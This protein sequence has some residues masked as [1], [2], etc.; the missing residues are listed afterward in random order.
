MKRL[1]FN[2]IRTAYLDFFESKGH[3]RLKSYS[4]VPQDDPSLLLINAGMAP[5]KKY[6]LGEKK[7]AKNR[8]TSSQRCVR[9]ADIENVGK[10][11]RHATYFEML[12]N[13]SFGDY[14]KNEAIHWAWE[15]LTRVIEL[16]PKRLWITVYKE[17]REAYR[18]WHEGIGVPEDRLLRLGKEDNF[19]ELDQGPCGP[20]SEIHYDRGPAFGPGTNPTDNSDR[21]MELWNLVFTQFNKQP[22]GSYLPI[23]HPNIDTGMGLERLALVLEDK[24]NIFEVEEFLPMREE[25]EKLS[26]KKYGEDPKIDESFRVIIDH[27][28]AVTFLAMDGVV[29]SNAGRG[30]ILRRL[31]RRAVRHGKLLG[32]QGEFLS[33]TMAHM[34]NVYQEEYPELVNAKDRILRVVLREEENFQGTI[35]QGAGLL[36][37]L[38][39]RR[40]EEGK[41]RLDGESV[42][43][44]YDTYG[45]PPDLTKEIALEEGLCID[46][47]GLE[48]AI[49]KQQEQ[50]KA[51]RKK[52][53]AWDASVRLDTTDLKET[54]FTGYETQADE[55]TVIAIFR[56]N[57]RVDSLS[58]DEEGLVVL[59]RT[60][61]YAEGGGQVSDFGSLTN[62][63][64]TLEVR[65]VS[66]DSSLIYF[67]DVLVKDGEVRVGDSLHAR[68][69]EDFRNDV[70]RN[71][72]AT[73]LL[74]KAL[75]TVLGDHVKQAGSY[76][77]DERLRFDFSHFEAMTPE[78]VR[79]TDELVNRAIFDSYP[80]NTQVCSLEEANRSGA[81]GLFEDKYRDR[82]RVVSMGDYSKEL[83]GGTHVD[84]TAQIMAFH[85]LS[86]QAV[87]AGVRRIEAETGRACL[88]HYREEEDRFDACASLLKTDRKGLQDKLSGLL[89]EKRN[90]EKQLS[91]FRSKMA[92]ALSQELEG[93]GNLVDGVQLY[94]QYLPGRSMEELKE[95]TDHLKENKE[96]YLIV[97]VSSVEDKVYWVV[98]CDPSLKAKGILAGKLVKSLAQIT[99]G[100]G[101]GRPDF[102]TAG[103][104][105]ASKIEEAL[106]SVESWIHGEGR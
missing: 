106:E 50:S 58:A 49:K 61:F 56:E 24:P 93:D 36:E 14:F 73:H 40:K 21:F 5:L 23:D 99:G 65:E 78:Q 3:I 35:D 63:H 105:D 104:K 48:E 52:D 25:I 74:H 55:G 71:H 1:G 17:D 96:N 22:D 19:W 9:T 2:E 20:C 4:L 86:E 28:K 102:A 13:F 89:E 100:N 83:C 29:P 31:L 84:N 39:R 32:I 82:V 85:I 18:I 98:S 75:R 57:E 30:Y 37:D 51:N 79:Q 44:L 92:D 77:D 59:D 11:A 68:I 8:A 38:I 64:A 42:F 7:M 10:T 15:F 81:I 94:K 69:Q 45:F 16:D 26:G 76:V 46:E 47:A 97:L 60:P 88:A 72:S 34:M 41:D 80:V 66:K 62:D 54:E 43:K 12:G 53:H 70:R 91:S 33:K 27:T 67:H 103:G 95:L 87:S 90:L 6:F 101:G